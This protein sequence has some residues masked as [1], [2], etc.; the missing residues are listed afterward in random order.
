MRCDFRLLR[1]KVWSRKDWPFH[2]EAIALSSAGTAG[3]GWLLVNCE[4]PIAKTS[5][6]LTLS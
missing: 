2:S 1:V 6:F 5:A 4:A 3:K